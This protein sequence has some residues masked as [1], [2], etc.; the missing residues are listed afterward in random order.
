MDNFIQ[1]LCEW[2]P[3]APYI[4]FSLLLLAGIGVPISEDV[5]I[6]SG[7]VI[8]NAC[9]PKQPIWMYTWVFFGCWFSAWLAY[10][11]GRLLGPKLYQ[12]PPISYWITEEK[13]KRLGQY[14]EHYGIWT[15]IA[16][17]FIPGGVRNALFMSCG[18][19]HMPFRTFILRDLP[20]CFVSSCSIFS[21]SYAFSAYYQDI[22]DL[23]KKTNFSVIII[24]VAI[25]LFFLI[26]SFLYYRK[27]QNEIAN[28]IK[29][30]K[31]TTNDDDCS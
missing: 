12:L 3:Y 6:I 7:G 9:L 2:A 16:G 26:K 20:A 15:F 19:S 21:L 11:I 31:E 14:Y 4:V 25:V 28:E 8:A 5:L 1:F 13:V 17:R 30:P 27:K 22:I 23:I 24:I 10:W 29:Y 18:L